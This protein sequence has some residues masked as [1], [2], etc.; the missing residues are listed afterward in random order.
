MRMLS[1]E[2]RFSACFGILT[3]FSLLSCNS[4]RPACNIF[5]LMADV[6][7]NKFYLC[8]LMVVDYHKLEIY[9]M[10]H[11]IVLDTYKLLAFFPENESNNLAS[12]LRRAVTCL[13]LNIAEGSGARSYKIF[14]NFC[15]FCYRSCR[16]VEAILELSKDLKYLSH[17]QYE[18][19]LSK[20]QLFMRKLYHYM[21]FLDR[22]IEERKSAWCQYE[23]WKIENN[24]T[25][26]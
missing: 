11:E 20:L 4:F 13:P 2:C 7:F 24:I 22:K 14:L 16:E 19:H 26:K 18:I 17:E 1:A 3:I 15:I 5:N 25:K 21:E 23:K 6:N 9:H 12:Q 10:A 8:V